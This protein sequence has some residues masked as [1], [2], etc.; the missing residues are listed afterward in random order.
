C[1]PDPDCFRLKR[2]LSSKLNVDRDSLI[3]SNGSDEIIVLTLRAF[4]NSA[5]EVIV[6]FPTFLIFEIQSIAQGANVISVPLMGFRYDLNAILSKISDKTKVIFIANPDNPTGT[7]VNKYEL[8]NFI[9]AVPRGIIVYL[10][11]A[12]FEFVEEG[13]FPDSLGYIRENPNIIVTR[14]FSKIYGLAGLRVGY[15]ISNPEIIS[16]LNKVREPFNVNSLAQAAAIAALKDKRHLENTKQLI[17]EQK[18]FLYREFEILKLRYIASATNFILVDTG[19]D[20]V[21]V[22]KELLKKGVIVRD[23]K[24][25]KL[26]TFIRVTIGKEQENKKFI[27]TFR[28]V[29]DRLK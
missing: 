10:D 12:Y 17:K 20:S 11:E 4:V 22:F 25:Y 13:D 19:F 16:Y 28:E 1:Y 26:D 24:P 21:C 29:L 6:S 5:D 9:R 14:T 15:G 2:A 23:M 3:I 8:D 18:Q 27:R 7:Y